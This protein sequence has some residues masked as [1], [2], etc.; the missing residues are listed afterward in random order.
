MIIWA[1][2]S[3]VWLYCF[4]QALIGMNKKAM[5]ILLAIPFFG[6]LFFGPK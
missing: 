1:G 6:Y 2:L 4:V 3:A 5:L